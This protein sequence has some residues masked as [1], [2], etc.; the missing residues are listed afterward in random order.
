MQYG[1]CGVQYMPQ[2]NLNLNFDVELT[3]SPTPL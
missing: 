2:A 3:T 1:V